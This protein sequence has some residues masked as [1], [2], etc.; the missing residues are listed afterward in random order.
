MVFFLVM[1]H[2]RAQNSGRETET[3]D[4]TTMELEQMTSPPPSDTFPTLLLYGDI[5]SLVL[6]PLFSPTENYLEEPV[7]LTGG[8]SQTGGVEPEPIYGFEQFSQNPS[9][10]AAAMTA[11]GI[12]AAPVED[13]VPFPDVPMPVIINSRR[14]KASLAS[15]NVKENPVPDFTFQ[16]SEE[17]VEQKVKRQKKRPEG[18]RKMHELDPRAFPNVK[19]AVYSRMNREKKVSLRKIRWFQSKCSVISYS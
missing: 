6:D 4:E 10:I 3:M 8:E 12:D 11:A 14:R 1:E 9:M 17:A 7:P 13:T 15:R 18:P 19:G 16:D 5:G 2:D